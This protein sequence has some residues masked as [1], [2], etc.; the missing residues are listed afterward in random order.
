MV[1]RGHM[2]VNVTGP[3]AGIND[4]GVVVGGGGWRRGVC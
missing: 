3:Y 1:I 4:G 2:Q